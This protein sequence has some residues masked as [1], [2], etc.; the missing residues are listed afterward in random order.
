MLPEKHLLLSKVARRMLVFFVL[1]AFIPILL[2]AYLTYWESTQLLIKEAHT[3]LEAASD[4]YKKSIYEKL[5]L[6]DQLLFDLV[7]RFSKQQWPMNAEQQ[8]NNRF[9]SLTI[10][11]EDGSLTR[12]FGNVA[13]LPT[14]NAIAKKHLSSN[15]SLL[16][17][18]YDGVETHIFMLHARD[19][20]LPEKG[21]VIAEVKAEFLW[22]SSDGFVMNMNLCIYNENSFKM[23]CTQPT[24]YPSTDTIQENARSVKGGFEWSLNKNNYLANYQEI[25][26]Q[27]KFLTLGG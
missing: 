22:G 18:Q 3:R 7:Q 8:L 11:A 20:L 15:Q 5:L 4:V 13:K 6:S 14:I 21:V 26:L 23:F 17:T 27:A 24:P 25:F 10:L 9:K 12:V 2:L 16:L 1:A 19:Y